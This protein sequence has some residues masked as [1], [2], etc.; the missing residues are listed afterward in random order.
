MTVV[1]LEDA[2][3][4]EAARKAY[5]Y[6]ADGGAPAPD[7]E[8]ALGELGEMSP[9]EYGRR[10]H[11]IAEKLGTAAA[12]LDLEY[13]ER[14]KRSKDDDGADALPPG[15]DPWPDRVDGRQ[16]LDDIQSAAADHL[17]LPHGAT[18]TIALWVVFTHTHDCFEISPVLAATSP[19]PE[20]GKTTLLTFLG[21]LVPSPLSASN[22]TAAALFRSVDK[23]GPTVLID[24]ADTFLR[25][26]DEL[27][28]ILNSGHNKRNA[29]VIRTHGESH[30]PRRF[31][32]WGPKAIALIGKLPPTLSSRCLHIKLQRKLSSESVI[33]LRA[34]RL[35]HLVPLHRMAARWAEDNM[36]SL[37][38]SDPAMPAELQSRMADNWRPLIAIADLVGE[39]WPEKAREIVKMTALAERDETAAI[40]LLADLQTIFERRGAHRLH[41]DEIISDLLDMEDRPWP[42]WR[43]G[44]PLTKEQLAKMLKAF[45]IAP[46]QTK[47]EGK[48]KN[49]YEVGTLTAAFSR[50]LGSTPLPSAETQGVAGDSS[51]YPE[52]QKVEPEK[53]ENPQKSAKGRTVE[54]QEAEP[55]EGGIPHPRFGHDEFSAVRMPRPN[56]K[57]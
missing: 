48:N 32:T 3:R 10:R 14:R 24:E 54:P 4:A 20:C 57:E 25:D 46:R 11:D 37:R 17:V 50:Y 21:E 8:R 42:D 15:P 43:H 27:R 34:D 45:E 31:R 1:K 12:Y 52:G 44:K 40:M 29:W 38:A 56:I 49:G 26:S 51:L 53:A 18:E 35:A 2:K 28:G 6:I 19:T 55:M 30:D 47:I 41:S 7:F 5:K 33:Q 36:H 16:L 23:W 22:I 39:P 13:K 9:A